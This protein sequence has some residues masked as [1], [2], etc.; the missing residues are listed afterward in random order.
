VVAVLLVGGGIA[1]ALLLT[2][3]RTHPPRL[4]NASQTAQTVTETTASPTT[5]GASTTT[6]GETST[7][8]PAQ[9]ST[10]AD[11]EARLFHTSDGN[12]A[13]EVQAESARC[14]VVSSD[15]TFVLPRGDS[16]AYVES[17]LALAANSGFLTAYGTSIS[18]GAV[19][20]AIPKQDEP[21]GITCTRDQSSHG[22][23]A[24]KVSSR[25][26]VH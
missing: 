9:T 21:K 16:P 13:C 17:G 15:Q 4:A 1:A 3:S 26:R 2:R 8:T 22:F 11:Q 14:A 18:V 25:Q 10:A 7:G 19:T 12:V 23:E 20:C 6:A 5:T 24:S